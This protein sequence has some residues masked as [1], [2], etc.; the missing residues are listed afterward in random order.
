MLIYI[1]M[2]AIKRML[3]ARTGRLRAG[4]LWAPL[5]PC[6]PPEPLWAG[7]LWAVPLRAPLGPCGPRGR[8]GP[9]RRCRVLH[10]DIK[11]IIF[12]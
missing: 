7:P 9:E 8:V 11:A 1:Y 3:C 6:G 2:L 4:P 12:V 5:G 10:D